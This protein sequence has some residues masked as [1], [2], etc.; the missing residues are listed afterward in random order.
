MSVSNKNHMVTRVV[1]LANKNI[2]HSVKFEFHV[3]DQ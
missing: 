1:N 3:N 2:G